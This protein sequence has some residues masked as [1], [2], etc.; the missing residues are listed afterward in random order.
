LANCEFYA[1]AVALYIIA[2][3]W[4]SSSTSFANPAI[5]V[6]RSR[7][8]IFAGMSLHDVPSVHLCA[9]AWSELGGGI[10]AVAVRL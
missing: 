5:T 10:G 6:A 8:Y 2:P 1:P 9:A 7:T 4:F 3:Y